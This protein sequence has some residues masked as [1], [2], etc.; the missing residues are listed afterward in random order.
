MPRRCVALGPTDQMFVVDI[1]LGCFLIS[2][3]DP[4]SCGCPQC[5]GNILYVLYVAMMPTWVSHQVNVHGMPVSLLCPNTARYISTS[6]LDTLHIGSM[7]S[8]QKTTILAQR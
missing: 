4:R 8:A 2:G 3:Q 5:S 7:T 6:S 1:P